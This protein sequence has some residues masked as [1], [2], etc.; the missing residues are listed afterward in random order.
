MYGIGPTDRQKPADQ[1]ISDGCTRAQP[2]GAGIGNTEYGFEKPCP[3]DD[4]RGGIDGEERQNDHGRND[5][6]HFGI[7]LEALR[8]IIRKGQGVV[9]AFGIDAQGPGDEFPVAPGPKNQANGD[10]GLRKAAEEQGS[11]QTQE[12]PAAHVR[13]AGGKRRHEAAHV[14]TAEDIVIQ[15]IDGSPGDETDCQHQKDVKREGNG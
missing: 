15:G 10:P 14:A 13:S 11:R 6:Q 1:G 2:N 9:A 4:A 7:I 3:G 8:E 12:Q 5:A